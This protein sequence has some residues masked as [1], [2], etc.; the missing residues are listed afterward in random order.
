MFNKRIAAAIAG[1]SLAASAAVAPAVFAEPI[2]VGDH[3]GEY[4]TGYVYTGPGQSQGVPVEVQVFVPNGMRLLTP[5]DLADDNQSHNRCYHKN[6]TT[7]AT[8]RTRS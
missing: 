4:Q 1:V 5:A 2:Q 6:S 8:T 7:A 3:W